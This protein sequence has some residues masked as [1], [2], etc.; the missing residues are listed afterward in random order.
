VSGVGDED[1]RISNLRRYLALQ[2]LG[3]HSNTYQCPP[4]YVLIQEARYLGVPPWSLL[5]VSTYW[6]DWAAICME[7]EAGARESVKNH[8]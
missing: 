4:E 3:A 1:P 5:E 8:G 2:A 7:A 6:G